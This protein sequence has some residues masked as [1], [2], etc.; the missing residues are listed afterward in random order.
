MSHPSIHA[1]ADAHAD[2]HPPAPPL[3]PSPPRSLLMQAAW[4]RALAAL[5]LVAA[6]WWAVAWAL[7]ESA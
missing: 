3:S 4:Q 6:L 7:G 2:P 5:G 1:H